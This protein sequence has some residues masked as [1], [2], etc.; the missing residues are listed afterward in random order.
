MLRPSR[1][2]VSASLQGDKVVDVTVGGRAIEVA[3]GFYRLP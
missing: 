2:T 1:L 3:E